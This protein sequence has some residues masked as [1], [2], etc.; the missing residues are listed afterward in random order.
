VTTLGADEPGKAEVSAALISESR[1]FCDDRTLTLEMGA[2]G[3]VGLD[4]A[5]ITGE[6]GEVL[7]GK[8]PGRLGDEFTVYGGVGLAWMDLVAA[9]SVYRAALEAGVERRIDFLA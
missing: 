1:F 2:A 3:N 9:W 8:Q 4:D 5:A 7:A 6:L